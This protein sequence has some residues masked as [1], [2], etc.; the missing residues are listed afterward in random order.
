MTYRHQLYSNYLYKLYQ[1][2]LKVVPKYS[3]RLMCYANLNLKNDNLKIDN[4]T[5][6][7]VGSNQSEDYRGS[8]EQTKRGKKT[9]SECDQVLMK[10]AKPFS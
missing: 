9:V 8:P 1:S 10:C 2:T 3:E 6:P 5:F 4:N 7:E